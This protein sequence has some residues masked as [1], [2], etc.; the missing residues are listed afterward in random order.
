MKL[1]FLGAETAVAGGDRLLLKRRQPTWKLQMQR[2]RGSETTVCLFDYGTGRTIHNSV[3]NSQQ[4]L[5]L[6][7]YV[8]IWTV[9][10]PEGV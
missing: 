3:G 8:I 2:E 1:K 6:A 10:I 9:K 5:N 7:G 4:N